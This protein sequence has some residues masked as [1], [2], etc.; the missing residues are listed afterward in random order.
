LDITVKNMGKLSMEAVGVRR[1]LG[2][3]FRVPSREAID[4]WA[5]RNVYLRPKA[6]ETPGYYDP[7]RTPYASLIT[8]WFQNDYG[9]S[10]LWFMKSSR[11]GGT[12]SALN[13]IRWM[14]GN[15]PGRVLYVI[16][17][18]EKAKD[19]VENRLLPTIRDVAADYLTGNEDDLGKTKLSLRNMII[20]AAGA[21]SESPFTEKQVLFGV[22]DEVEQHELNKTRTASGTTVELMRSRFPTSPGAKMLVISKPVLAGG[23]MDVGWREGTMEVYEVPCA[24]CGVMQELVPDNLRF[25]HCKDVFSGWDLERVLAE[26]YYE[27]AGCGGQ[28]DWHKHQ[29]GMVAGGRWR[30]TNDKPMPGRR[31]AHISDLYSPYDAVSWGRLAL[32]VVKAAGNDRRR[33]FMVNNHWG[34][35]WAAKAMERKE[36]DLLRLRAGVTD[37]ESKEMLGHPFFW[38]SVKA[39]RQLPVV[40]KLLCIGIDVQ[41][42]CLKYVLGAF[43]AA[44][45]LSLVDYGD[46]AGDADLEA[47]VLD[48]VWRDPEGGEHRVMMGWRDAGY[49]KLQQVDWCMRTFKR[50]HVWPSRGEGTQRAKSAVWM[51]VETYEQ[52]T[53]QIYYYADSVLKERLYLEQIG[54]LRRPRLWL[55]TDADQHP[56]F[57]YELTNERR[58]LDMKSGYPQWKWDLPQGK[59]NDYGDCCK[60]LYGIWMEVGAKVSAG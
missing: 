4:L 21:G 33:Q 15:R 55:P 52:R 59:P 14:P 43:D 16:E 44:G 13:C 56:G 32:G 17:T 58:I 42:S 19:V 24:L 10:E 18:A 31:S 2:G 47:Q 3:C 20:E 6:T 36:E 9:N 53:Y 50:Y 22:L 11:T 46:P 57:L 26:T 51:K 39:E 29:A 54:E 1:V 5:G 35:P 7:R 49:Q 45:E 25:A 27:C 8:D 34:K 41:Q 60:M 30:A 37:V 48:R 12:E 28:L 40:P 23:I 38:G